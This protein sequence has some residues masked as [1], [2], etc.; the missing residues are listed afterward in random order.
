M[1][2]NVR[3]TLDMDVKSNE[4]VL[5]TLLLGLLDVVE[6][7]VVHVD[8]A[9]RMLLHPFRNA[10]LAA[11]GVRPEVLELLEASFFLGDTWRLGDASFRSTLKQLRE[12]A[13]MCL[14]AESPAP[15]R[16]RLSVEGT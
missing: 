12:G 9:E 15:L 1:T 7:G 3:M 5:L 16:V 2:E 14:T 11:L 13:L 6:R 10:R 8:D 4:T